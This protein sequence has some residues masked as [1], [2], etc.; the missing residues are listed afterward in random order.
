MKRVIRTLLVIIVFSGAAYGYGFKKGKI[1]STFDTIEESVAESSKDLVTTVPEPDGVGGEQIIDSGEINEDGNIVHHIKGGETLFTIGLQYDVLWTTIAKANNIDENTPLI[2]DQTLIIPITKS[3]SFVDE[4]TLSIDAEQVSEV[5]THVD[6][7]KYLWRLDPVATV[8]E[9][10]PVEYHLKNDDTYTLNSLDT[11]AGKST[12]EVSHDDK[13]L[14][15][16]LSQPG[17]KGEKGVWF[18]SNIKSSYN[19]NNE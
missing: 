6:N 9:D 12:V 2:A 8:R 16:E 10:T 13:I 15:I 18:I 3:G 11:V 14:T 19:D 5:Q 17:I 1:I 7:G 4:E